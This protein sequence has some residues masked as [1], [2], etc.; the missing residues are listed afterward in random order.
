MNLQRHVF[1]AL[2]AAAVLAG[3]GKK[4]SNN[5]KQG[6]APKPNQPA[7]TGKPTQYEIK[8]K[9]LD[10]VITAPEGLEVTPIGNQIKLGGKGY[11]LR[12]ANRLAAS[13]PDEFDLHGKPTLAKEGTAKEI[14]KTDEH[15][16]VQFESA[17]TN[18]KEYKL[19]AVK[20]VG[21]KPVHATAHNPDKAKIDEM[22]K[23]VQSVKAK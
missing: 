22:L 21:D 1:V 11:D 13:A 18:N 20:K 5:D 9:D 8:I 7:V 2:A 4:D 19:V 17:L 16:I 6:P 10:L 3:C 23:W 14:A 15:L 12:F